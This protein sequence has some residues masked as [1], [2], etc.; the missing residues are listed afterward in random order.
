MPEEIFP[1]PPMGDSP[2]F[3]AEEASSAEEA[4]DS[5]RMVE[6]LGHLLCHTCKERLEATEH[7][8]RRLAGV[9]Y[10]RVTLECKNGHSENRVYRLDWLKGES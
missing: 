3:T 10:S 6:Q 2:D 1:P 8:L 9:H 7:A 4:P 5:Q